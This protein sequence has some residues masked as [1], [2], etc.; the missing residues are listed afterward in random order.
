MRSGTKT[1]KSVVVKHLCRRVQ[2]GHAKKGAAQVSFCE[3]LQISEIHLPLLRQ[4]ARQFA[5]TDAEG[6][7]GV[8]E[9]CEEIQKQRRCC[10]G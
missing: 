5:R 4:F 8:V 9:G 6:Q 7:Q 10:G 3:K 1:R 2:G